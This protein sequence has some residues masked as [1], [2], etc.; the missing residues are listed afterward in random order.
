M[1]RILVLAAAAASFAATAAPAAKWSIEPFAVC[2][3]DDSL[4]GL[5]GITW[6]GGS[7]FWAVSDRSAGLH[8]LEVVISDAGEPS[9]SC[10]AG[11]AVKVAGAAD[12]EGCAFDPLRGTLWVSDEKDTSIREV[13]PATGIRGASAP[14]AGCFAKARR[15]RSLESLAI[16]RDALE[17]WTANEEALECDGPRATGASGTVVRI[18]RFV[19]EGAED[20]WRRAGQWAAVTER[21]SAAGNMTFSN[22]CGV[23]DLCVMPDGTLVMLERE[24]SGNMLRFR[25]YEMDMSC[26]DDVTDVPSLAGGGFRPVAKRLI[27]SES[28]RFSI[29]RQNP[30]L[31]NY[32]GVCAGPRLGRGGTALVLVSDSGDGFSRPLLKVLRAMPAASGGVRGETSGIKKGE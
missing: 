1:R 27:H 23:S 32:E 22:C 30:L 10:S 21:L 12:L 8:P 7:S 24:V 5:S 26:A 9:V 28:Q 15:N 29:L 16:S 4:S 6:K 17:M 19:R 2:E 20:M 25:L 11:A 18:A 31:G 3:L 13:D 14:L